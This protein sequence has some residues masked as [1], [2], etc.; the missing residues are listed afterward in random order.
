[1]G[2]S[3]ANQLR[4]LTPADR[5]WKQKLREIPTLFGQ[6]VF[7]N[8]LRDASGTYREE[9]LCA[10]FGAQEADRIIRHNHYQVFSQWLA[11]PLAEQKRDIGNYLTGCSGLERGRKQ[12][13]SLSYRQIIPAAAHEVERQLYLADLETL[14]ELLKAEQDAASLNR[15]A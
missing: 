6:L 1:V 8:S 11:Y 15:E 5:I 14:L 7:L 2:E 10:M 12:L 9:S 13:A 4:R 3:S